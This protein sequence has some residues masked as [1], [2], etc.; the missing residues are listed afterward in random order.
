MSYIGH[1]MDF[2]NEIKRGYS[3]IDDVCS[4]IPN[5]IVSGYSPIGFVLDIPN[6][7]MQKGDKMEDPFSLNDIITLEIKS[8]YSPTGLAPDMK[9][10]KK[11]ERK[12]RIVQEKAEIKEYS[13]AAWR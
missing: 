9:D 2:P 11:E 5:D 12:Y 10:D 3:P 7:G 6:E 8:D 13:A 1:L 4:G